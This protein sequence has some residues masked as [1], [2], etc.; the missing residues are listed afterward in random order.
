[1]VKPLFGADCFIYVCMYVYIYIYIYIYIHT[2]THTHRVSR[3]ECKKLRESVPY[4]K[5]Y[6]YNLKYLYTKLHGYGDNGQ[7]KLWTSLWLTHCS[8]ELITSVC[9]SF[10]VASYYIS[11]SLSNLHTF[12][13]IRLYSSQISCTVSW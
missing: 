5:I 8:C 9:P 10:S 1:V 7:R 6:Q 13:L 2:H 11:H 3:E 4:V 12:Q